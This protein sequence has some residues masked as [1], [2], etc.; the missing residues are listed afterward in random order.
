MRVSIW[1][2]LVIRCAS[3]SGSF[4]TMLV[5]GGVHREVEQLGRPLGVVD[6]VGE[7]ALDGHRLEVAGDLVEHE[8]GVHAAGRH[9]HDLGVVLEVEERQALPLPGDPPRTVL[10]DVLGGLSLEVAD[11]G[12]G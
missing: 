10:D 12:H 3:R 7:L 1:M 5:G 11:E 2:M 4:E 6:A 9:G 8:V